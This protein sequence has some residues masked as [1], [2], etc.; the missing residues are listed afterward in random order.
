MLV[1]A[2]FGSLRHVFK[3]DVTITLKRTMFDQYV[4]PPLTYGAKTLSVTQKITVKQKVVQRR[5]KRLMIGVMLN[6]RICNEDLRRK[7]K[8]K[9]Y[10]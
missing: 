4:L 1:W 5:K 7:N 3:G 9:R 2:A 10:Y 6:H 8:I